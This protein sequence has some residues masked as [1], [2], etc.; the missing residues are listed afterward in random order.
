MTRKEIQ[1]KEK[2]VRDKKEKLQKELEK[3]TE[4]EYSL[5]RE[6]RTLDVEEAEE[7]IKFLNKNKDVI[8]K[9]APPHSKK[10]CSDENPINGY[11]DNGYPYCKRC[12]LLSLLNGDWVYKVS[13]DIEFEEI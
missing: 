5:S 7:K 4:E 2:E 9:I 10:N 11:M 13:F 1:D 12:M 8:M 6:K 3:L